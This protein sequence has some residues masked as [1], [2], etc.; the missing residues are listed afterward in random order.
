[1]TVRKYVTH[2]KVVGISF[3][4][5]DNTDRQSIVRN[6]TKGEVLTLRRDSANLFDKNSIEVITA[7]G[8]KLGF[9]NRELAKDL[10]PNLD[11]GI[12]IKCSVSEITG[13]DKPTRGVN[14]LLE[15][16]L[17]DE[18]VKSSAEHGIQ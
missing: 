10:A 16:E 7:S 12:M 5:E 11:K 17:P 8:H 18:E 1:M 6:L 3:K 14:I 4:N 15:G 9:I 13:M 2:S